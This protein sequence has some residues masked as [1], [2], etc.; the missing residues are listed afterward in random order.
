M[1]KIENVVQEPIA[2]YEKAETDLLREAINRTYTERFH[3][4]TSLM[5]LNLMFR[6]AVI[7]HKPY[8]ASK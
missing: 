6:K 2:D 5:K 8:H 3:M 1:K 4:M 7:K